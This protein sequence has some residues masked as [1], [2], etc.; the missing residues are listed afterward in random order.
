MEGIWNTS[1]LYASPDDGAFLSDAQDAA[2]R[3]AGAAAVVDALGKGDADMK[4]Q[5][6]EAFGALEAATQ[7]YTRVSTYAT[8]L[9]LADS[10]NERAAEL[11]ERFTNLK[12]ELD[13]A[14][15]RL[16][17]K[18]LS[19]P[20]IDRIRSDPRA[21][22]YA[23]YLTWLEAERAHVLP[24]ELNRC[25]RLMQATGSHAWSRLRA[26][27]ETLATADIELDGDRKHLPLPAMRGMQSH[28]D[29]TVRRRAFEAE[30]K[31]SSEIA[32]VSAACLNAIKGE[33]LIVADMRGFSSPLA[34]ML[35]I[36]KMTRPTLDAMHEA[37]EE[38]LPAFA[39]YVRTKARLLGYEHTLPYYELNTPVG[40][41]KKGF[42]LGEAGDYLEATLGRADK[43]LGT[44]VRNAF[45]RKWIDAYPRRGKYGGGI[46]VPVPSI[47]ESRVMVN[48]NGGFGDMVTIAHE[49]GHAFHDRCTADVPL[50]LRDA[51]TPVCETASTF[52]ET[53]VYRTA[54][55]A[56]LPEEKLAVLDAQLTGAC[57]NI[58]DIYSR[59]L[60]EDAVFEKRKT[61]SLTERELCGLMERCQKRAYCGA[62]DP[63][64]LHPYM[65]IAK[66]HYYIPNFH[67]YNF[68]YAFGL[69]FSQGLYA[70]SQA[71]PEGFFGRYRT[72]LAATCSDTLEGV[73]ARAG[74]DIAQ[75]A[76]WRSALRVFTDMIERFEDT[77]KE[78]T[79]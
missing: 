76:F 25:V 22:P 64:A 7:A 73:G 78:V 8:M 33:A 55:D 60:F 57:R 23:F 65:W 62:L 20:D 27:A 54:E 35:H 47:N 21:E 5:V 2:A 45:K 40:C 12:A 28:A 26:N 71:E 30:I 74:I 52:N 68:P 50:F 59:F 3:V 6:F 29:R 69:L 15:D 44:F 18:L 39:R 19:L 36:N 79:V 63:D 75:I 32:A 67:Y 58:V 77:A 31:A 34:W 1:R 46:C 41:M 49:L 70:L 10:A 66:P 43:S 61:A 38:S 56:A 9:S 42:T 11:N 17:E 51:P 14:A 16:A 53:L 37:I 24:A 48:F 72:L 4:E 13:L